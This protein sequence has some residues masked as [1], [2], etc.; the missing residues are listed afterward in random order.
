MI[1]EQVN[2]ITLCCW[3]DYDSGRHLGFSVDYTDELN[4]YGGGN[5]CDLLSK[6]QISAIEFVIL[7]MV[8]SYVKENI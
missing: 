3:S 4:P 5:L 1:E 6:E 2:G 8:S 7:G